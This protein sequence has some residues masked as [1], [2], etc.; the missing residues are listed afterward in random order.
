MLPSPKYMEY[1]VDLF[2]DHFG[3]RFLFLHRELVRRCVIEHAFPAT[4]ANCIASLALRFS[5]TP[6]FEDTSRHQV[7]DAY[8]EMAKVSQ[9]VH[10]RINYSVLTSKRLIGLD[11]ASNLYASN[12]NLA[13]LAHSGLV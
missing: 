13:L 7:G 6:E 9:T 11:N 5:Q 10:T 12:R 4:L 8:L 1:S 2:F 3:S